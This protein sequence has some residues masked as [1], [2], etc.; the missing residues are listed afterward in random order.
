M[1]LRF[2]LTRKGVFLVCP[3]HQT[4]TSRMRLAPEAPRAFLRPTWHA[5]M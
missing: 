5:S 1:L 4:D 3:L 2:S